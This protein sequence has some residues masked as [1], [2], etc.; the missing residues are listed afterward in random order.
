MA[1]GAILGQ[2]VNKDSLKLIQGERNILSIGEFKGAL[3]YDM[4]NITYHN[5][6]YGNGRY[7]DFSVIP[8][9]SSDGIHWTQTSDSNSRL[10]AGP[11]GYFNGKFFCLGS[12]STSWYFGWSGD[13]GLT[14]NNSYRSSSQV[15]LAERFAVGPNKVIAVGSGGGQYNNDNYYDITAWVNSGSTSDLNSQASDGVSFGISS[16]TSYC[17]PRD[18]ATNGS[19]TWI[20]TFSTSS[21]ESN[22]SQ[23]L[24]SNND[25]ATWR[26]VNLPS[27]QLWSYIAYGDGRFV[28][29]SSQGYACYST[30]NGSSWTQFTIPKLNNDSYASY[31]GILDFAYSG[32]RFVA[33]PRSSSLGNLLISGENFNTTDWTMLTS[34]NQLTLNTVYYSI[35]RNAPDI[36]L[37]TYA[38]D[39]ISVSTDLTTEDYI[40]T[41][42]SGADVTANVATALEPYLG[43]GLVQTISQE[44]DDI[45][46][47][48]SLSNVRFKPYS[49]NFSGNNIYEINRLYL[50]EY[51]VSLYPQKLSYLNTN[52][53]LITESTYGSFDGTYLWLGVTGQG[54]SA[55]ESLTIQGYRE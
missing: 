52:A 21:D 55:S 31:Y 18:I 4:S 30:N 35:T 54:S 43:T 49:L 37:G 24:V 26:L 11:V 23:V 40:I 41:N 53:V 19:G 12:A 38:Y 7:V 47:D 15:N 13:N 27:S 32:G 8:S 6:G 48:D 2:T 16:L 45:D 9:Y 22:T 34:D 39:G 10:F 3:G 44:F 46:I 1:Y 36:V 42:Q 50:P 5:V 33:S 17:Y 28:I 29:I 25:C 20:V 51:N 14:W